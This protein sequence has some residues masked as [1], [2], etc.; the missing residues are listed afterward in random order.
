[1]EPRQSP[2][3]VE[4]GA[5][6][7]IQKPNCA[8]PEHVVFLQEKELGS[9][10]ALKTIPGE[11]VVC[12]GPAAACV[13]ITN[14][15]IAPIKRPITRIVKRFRRVAIAGSPGVF[16]FGL[17]RRELYLRVPCANLMPGILSC[18]V[19]KWRIHVAQLSLCGSV[20]RLP[21]LALCSSHRP[22]AGRVA[23]D[24]WKSRRAS[25]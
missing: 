17:S 1:M 24:R 10:F 19:K 20:L 23:D 21:L 3:L 14:A 9:A 11:V 6:H 18:Q 4:V 5:V 13:T 22:L 25:L 15:A 16:D 7:Q 12:C 2:L 8:G